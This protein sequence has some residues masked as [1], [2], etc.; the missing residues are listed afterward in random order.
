MWD[1]LL[2]SR[3]TSLKPYVSVALSERT[4][5]SGVLGYGVGE[6]S[7]PSEHGDSSI[8]TSLESTLAAMGGRSVI[9]R[10]AGGFELAIV[11]DALFTS[12]VRSRGPGETAPARHANKM[13]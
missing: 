12:R 10:H 5:L 11:S 6:L 7:L 3:L 2:T 1:I 4:S 8:E 9:F 13:A